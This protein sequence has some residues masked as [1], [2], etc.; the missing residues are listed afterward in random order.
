MKL[1]NFFHSEFR[2]FSIYDCERSIPNMIDGLKT[3]QRKVIYAM[4]NRGENAQEIQVE[5]FANYASAETDYHHGSAGLIGVS[6]GLAQNF[7]G[8]NNI[9]L[10][11]PNGQFGSRLDPTPGAG[12][13]IFTMLS[14]SFRQIFK[15]EDDP[16]L[17][18]LYSED[19]KIE[20]DT[21]LP[22]LPMILV[23]GSSGTG[24]G[25][26]SNIFQYNPEELKQNILL[27][28]SK[29]KMKD[30]TP[31][32]K[33]FTGKV[34]RNDKQTVI[35]GK[36]EI[37]SSTSIRITE[38]PIGVYQD[39][40]KEI[41]L[42]L[43]DQEI[44]KSFSDSSTEDG[45][46]IE[47]TC[48]RT[49]TYLDHDELMKTFKLISR[50]T[51]NFT[52]WGHD[53]KMKSFDSPNEIIEYFVD[54][55]LKKYEER[56]LKQIEILKEELDWSNEKLKFVKFYIANAKDFAKQG[57]KELFELLAN[58]GFIQ[59]DRLLSLKIYTLTKD[60]IVQLEKDIADLKTKI[61]VLQQ[62]NAKDM[63]VREL[64]ELKV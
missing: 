4:L 41:L 5:R 57:K 9:N 1:E 44:I 51:E 21:Y 36:Y 12:R 25:Y 6:A 39:A 16:I 10:L 19:L 54:F 63:Y 18:H 27:Y 45:F 61:L 2:L 64:K 28:L 48:P 58:N 50:D 30:L 13:Y 24:T 47:I 20:P 42:K 49:T 15:K 3:S 34:Y 40:Y 38:L 60:S 53:G 46:D 32:F 52:A 33:G 11:E 29:K 37:E 56:R 31:W 17:N 55:R 14:K 22:I 8:S 26:A 35:E 62:D 59:I 7:A 23:N 43:Q